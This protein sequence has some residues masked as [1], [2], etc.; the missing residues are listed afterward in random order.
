MHEYH[1]LSR[2]D[3]SVQASNPANDRVANELSH[4][5][6]RSKVDKGNIWEMVASMDSSSSNYIEPEVRGSYAFDWSLALDHSNRYKLNWAYDYPANIITFGLEIN[7]SASNFN[8]GYDV[9][10]LGFSERGH[11]NSSDFCLIWYDLAHRLHLQDA[12]TDAS[13]NLKLISKNRGACKLLDHRM[14]RTSN[15]KRSSSSVKHTRI[16]SSDSGNLLDVTFTRALDV[17][18][19]SHHYKIDN[20]TTH[21]VWFSLKGPLLSLDGLDVGSLV[22]SS[23]ETNNQFDWGMQRVQLIA[24]KLNH[25][26][27]THGARNS[28]LPGHQHHFDVRMD[29][30][31]VSPKETTY[32]CKL[33]KLPS[34]FEQHKFHITKYQPLIS[35]GNEHIVHHME[36]FNCANLNPDKALHLERLYH[37][38]G[39]WSGE[40]DSPNRP[41][42][43][44]PCRR[45]IMA[46]AMGAK[47]FEYPS[48]VGQTIGGPG[49]S[50]FVVLEVHYNNVERRENVIDSSGL[51]YHYTSRLRPF[52]AG[53]LEVGLEYTPKNSIPPSMLAPIAGYCV[54][55]C[56][57]VA[58]SK[59]RPDPELDESEAGRLGEKGQDR[60]LDDG[61]IFIFAAQLHTHL[62]GT[63]TWTEH[64]REGELVGELQR[65][66]HYSPHFQ[67]IR[68]LAEP[69]YIAPGDAL[70]HYCLYD[71]RQRAN[72]TL[73]GFA[74]TDEMCVTYLHYY[75]RIDLE[76]CKSSVDSETLES[77]FSYLARAEAQRTS[78]KLL[79]LNE[80]RDN[81]LRDSGGDAKSIGENYR[82]IEWSEKRSLELL[83]FYANSP[84]SVQCNRSDGRRFPG[85]WNGIQP[86]QMI[87]QRMRL[88]SD[89]SKL[90]PVNGRDLISYRGRNFMKRHA[91]CEASSN[92]PV[93][94]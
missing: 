28:H 59:S 50:P 51:R 31:P 5:L 47:A 56:T 10:A 20:G 66:D 21:L 70:I 11:L 61:G 14:P 92:S 82:S 87:R 83:Q 8:P 86:P 54:S 19:S 18:D 15:V 94:G 3:G 26:L 41:T 29:K 16:S 80:F 63:A 77:Y 65:D 23:K 58:M 69:R 25:S 60:R 52:D 90:E 4:K 44:D 12:R 91:Q 33:F 32:L 35:E 78:S 30:Y 93:G 22:A 38:E 36:L 46:W 13:I 72:I 9:F 7:L 1:N 6:D 76:V 17:C 53:I 73:G 89:P 42:A 55:E 37:L 48:Q 64:I 79:E 88:A 68:L 67:E 45:V 40:C 75:P 34:K 62:T 27:A 39:G 24:T 43:L 49:Y 85:Y 71:T 57:R 2:L 81:E 74:T 84:L